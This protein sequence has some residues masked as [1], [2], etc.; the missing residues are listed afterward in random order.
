MNSVIDIRDGV[1][2]EATAILAGTEGETIQNEKLAQLA[3]R[4]LGQY[5]IHSEVTTDSRCASNGYDEVLVT[6]F[7]V[8][9]T[10]RNP[11]EMRLAAFIISGAT[12]GER[13]ARELASGPHSFELSF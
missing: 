1:A 5:G 3:H 9:L 7:R 10:P 4:W 6:N 11:M 2:E 8:Q 12:G 13:G